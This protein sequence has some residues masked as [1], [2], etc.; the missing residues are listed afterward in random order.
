MRDDRRVRIL[1][2]DALDAARGELDVDVTV[3]LPQIHLAA[4]LLHDPRAEILVGHEEDIAVG[5]RG[6]DDFLRVAARADDVGERFHA[7]AAIDVGD[8]VIVFLRV[9]G[10]K[11]RQLVRRTGFGKRAAGVEIGQDHF[12]RRVQDLG[13][14]GHEMDAAEENDFGVGLR[15]LKAQ[16]RASRRRNRPRPEFPAPGSYARG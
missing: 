7:G 6:P 14:L 1:A 2:L 8:D 4:G 12:L 11:T 3:A 5:R 13:G 10:E 15:R 9:L 16:S